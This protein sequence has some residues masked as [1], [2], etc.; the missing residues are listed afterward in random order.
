MEIVSTHAGTDFDALAAMVACTRLHRDAK[1]V[2][3]G[4]MRTNVREFVALHRDSYQFYRPSQLNLDAC[5]VLYMVDTADCVRLGAAAGLCERAEKIVV[6]DHH[7]GPLSPGQ[8]GVR[9][10]LGAATTI[11]VEKLREQGVA[12]SQLD[13]TLFM[14]GIYEDTNCLILDTTT[15]RDLQAAAWLLAQGANLNEVDKYVNR[16]LSEGERELFEEMLAASSIEAINNRSVL[17]TVANVP[18]YVG[19]LG[20]LTQRLS[21][22]EA[23]DLAISIVQMEDRVHL[24][25]RSLNPGLNLLELLAPM[26]VAGHP[27]AVALTIQGQSPGDIRERVLS[28]LREKLEIG[29]IASDVMS[30][31]VKTI[32]ENKPIADANRLLLRYGHTGMPVIN[33]FKQLVGV[34][35]R[36]DVDKAMRHGL[37]HA[38]VKGYMSRNV[39]TVKPDTPLES[40]THLIIHNDIGRLPVLEKNQLVGIITRTDILRQIH[41]ESAPRWHRA[42]YS[43]VD[44]RI[45]DKVNNVTQL[46]N[47]R[48]PKRLQGLLLL[49]GQKADKEGFKVYAIGGFVRDLILGLPNYDLDLVVED[50]AIKF[51]SLLPPLLGGKLHVHEEFGTACLT[52]PDGF[53][54]DFATARMEFYQFPAAQPEVEQTSIKHDLYRRDFTINTM[55]ICLNSSSFGKFLDFFGGYEDLEAGLIRVL[56]N[57]SFVEDPTRILRAVRFAGRYGFSIEA[58]TGVL[59]ENAIRDRILTRAPAARIGHELR[60]LFQ[61]P[62]VPALLETAHEL[63]IIKGIFPDLELS[64]SLSE[65][66]LAAGQVLDWN[67]QLGDPVHPAWLIYPLLLLRQVD[68]QKRK[69]HSERMGL[70]AAELKDVLLVLEQ[71]DTIGSQLSVRDLRD[72]TIYQLLQG[73]PVVGLLALMAIFHDQQ[74]LRSRVVFYLEELADVELDI[75][76]HDLLNLGF[77][78]GPV[79]GRVLQALKRALLDGEINSREQQL[80]LAR[81]L[82]TWQEG[83]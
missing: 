41:G 58:Q 71:A 6:Y 15:V 27:G 80:S 34:I 2:L 47:N 10:P 59:L 35:S 83:E 63:G 32:D 25:G 73:W 70:T 33:D 3:P 39:V 51:A 74:R 37:G 52:L 22:L 48:L 42:L 81:E 7:P 46:I 38:P 79:I 13:A 28:I 30:A 49:L 21:E 56:Y 65:Q 53:Q 68:T 45:A 43:E 77:K 5:S 36:R 44:F 55:A 64:E 50:N 57:L 11:L 60:L 14:L 24:V 40:V 4:S 72:S 54:I 9:E 1:M 8:T 16:P 67:E 78:P 23:C 17:V 18:E 66:V 69:E 75:N 29:K 76:G 62:N 82:L 19:G 12:L 20:R 26:N 31:P 61:E